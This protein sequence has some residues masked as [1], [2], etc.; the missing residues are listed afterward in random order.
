MNG[1]TSSQFWSTYMHACLNS[2]WDN[3]TT[4]EPPFVDPSKID[5]SPFDTDSSSFLA[6]LLNL[7]EIFFKYL[8]HKVSFLL[9][10]DLLQ[11]NLLGGF[12]YEHMT[13]MFP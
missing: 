9:P 4:S 11:L 12:Y 2:S 10:N 6:G 13:L 3:T 7:E 5:I 8:E 1:Q